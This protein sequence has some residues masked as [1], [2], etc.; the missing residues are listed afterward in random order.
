MSNEPHPKIIVDDDWKTR[1][2]K[3]KE[4]LAQPQAEESA[5]APAK[6]AEE[7][8]PSRNEDSLPLP[9]F[10]LLVST[11]ATEALAGLGQ[12]PGPDNQAPTI[13]L[14]HA[15]HFIDTLAMLQEKTKGNLARE[16][17][18]ML[19]NILHELRMVFVA[20]SARR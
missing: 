6:K 20:V 7:P 10:A 14:P 12:I 16:E 18:A 5:T 8:Q 1:V 11:L 9:S 4:T 13:N 15:K 2:Q 19:E 3:E 17:A